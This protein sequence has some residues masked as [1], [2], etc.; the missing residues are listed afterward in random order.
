[1]RIAAIEHDS[2]VNGVG[3][4]TVIYTQGCK[5]KCVG[6]HN[7]S[8]WDFNAGY[9]MTLDEI[10]HEVKKNKLSKSITWSGGDPVYQLDEVLELSKRL[11]EEGYD[12]WLYTGF[13]YE[14]IQNK[15][16]YIDVVVDGLFEI[17]KRTLDIPF[18]GS[19]NQRII[20]LTNKV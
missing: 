9:E 4:R 17:D 2:V 6:C 7:P 11:K 15:L 19:S 10:Y 14:E 18:V 12:I 13:L 16:C 20:H 5:H 8:T 1:M 3:C